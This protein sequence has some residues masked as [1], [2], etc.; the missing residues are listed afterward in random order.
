MDMK[1]ILNQTEYLA[2]CCN[3]SLYTPNRIY[4]YI[5]TNNIISKE[6]YK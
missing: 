2:T 4:I 1:E 6:L 5:K 3:I